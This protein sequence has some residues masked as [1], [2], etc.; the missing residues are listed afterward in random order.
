MSQQQPKWPVSDLDGPVMFSGDYLET[1]NK[2]Y[3]DVDVIS[4]LHSAREYMQHKFDCALT[5]NDL[6][7]Y[8]N[9]WL[10][11]SQK[12]ATANNNKFVSAD[13]GVDS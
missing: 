10:D 3:P 2:K 1:L 6:I 8:I 13:E 12:W 4:Q 7:T 5:R 9:N 11:R